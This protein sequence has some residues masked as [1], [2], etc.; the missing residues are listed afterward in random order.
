[1]IVDL[2]LLFLLIVVLSWREVQILI[3]RGSWKEKDLRFN[4]FWNINWK[5]KWKNFDSF[6][7]SNGI[8]TLIIIEMIIDKLPI[9]NFGI[10]HWLIMQ[11]YV[12]IYWFIFMQVR[13]FFMQVVFKK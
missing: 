6:H 5:S 1:M 10:E 11:V 7:V 2:I 12:V 3:D 4:I 8:A 13:N 9:Y